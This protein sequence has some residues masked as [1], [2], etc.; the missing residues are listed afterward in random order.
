MKINDAGKIVQNLKKKLTRT[1]YR[2]LSDGTTFRKNAGNK[3]YVKMYFTS[4]TT[5]YK[6][7]LGIERMNF[8]KFKKLHEKGKFTKYPFGSLSE[9]VP[10]NRAPL[11]LKLIC[12]PKIVIYCHV[13]NF[14]LILIIP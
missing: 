7:Y 3:N 9:M 11:S 6:N 1:T 13:L 12:I 5:I 8:E 4:M 14:L 2:S 10:L